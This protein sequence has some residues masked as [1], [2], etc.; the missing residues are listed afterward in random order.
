MITGISF[1]AATFLKSKVPEHPAS[2]A[3]LQYGLRFIINM[4]SIVLF[5]LIISLITGRVIETII[6]M[7]G[8]AILRQFSG[9]IHLKS[10]E[11]CIVVS[12]MLITLLSFSNFNSTTTFFLNCISFF[13]ISIFAPSNITQQ[14]RIPTKYHGFLKYISLFIIVI[15]FIINNPVLSTAFLVQ[16]LTLYSKRR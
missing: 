15:G 7:L 8:F 5:S 13:M 6:A 9:G 12:V 3:V 10:G 4:F 14:T 2:I 11:L 16:S 1:K